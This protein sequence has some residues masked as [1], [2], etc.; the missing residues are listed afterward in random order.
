MGPRAAKPRQTATNA[1]D[2][3]AAAAALTTGALVLNWWME[4]V[5]RMRRA[6]IKSLGVTPEAEAAR[7]LTGLR[8]RVSLGNMP[9]VRVYGP[10]PAAPQDSSRRILLGSA[11]V[12]GGELIPNRLLSPAEIQG[13]LVQASTA[14]P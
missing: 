13:L 1:K 12:Q 9:Q 2:S 4:P 11:H 14:T 6:L 7:F 3:T 8:R 5:R 10:H